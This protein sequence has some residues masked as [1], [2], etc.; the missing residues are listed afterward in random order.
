VASDALAGL[1]WPGG[2]WIEEERGVVAGMGAAR[3]GRAVV[4]A[5]GGQAGAVEALDGVAVGGL[6]GTPRRHVR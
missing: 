2:V 1:G 4:A 5:A 6:Q 3:T